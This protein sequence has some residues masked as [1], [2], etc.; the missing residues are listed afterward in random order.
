M[1]SA[2]AGARLDAT[3]CT[4][5]ERA[6]KLRVADIATRLGCAIGTVAKD[7]RAK[8][9]APRPRRSWSDQDIEIIDNAIASPD[10]TSTDK[11]L[12]AVLAAHFSHKESAVLRQIRVRNARARV[13]RSCARG[14]RDRVMSHDSTSHAR[15]RASCVTP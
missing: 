12:A 6:S 14:E 10:R 13:G 2:R 9:V 15:D 1:C 5:C 8:G 4:C 11:E 3:Q 7:L